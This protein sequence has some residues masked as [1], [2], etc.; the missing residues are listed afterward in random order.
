M[1]PTP[2]SQ[3]N[4]RIPHS[5]RNQ[6]DPKRDCDGADEDPVT[7]EVIGDNNGRCYP[8]SR[9]GQNCAR[10]VAAAALVASATTNQT[11]LIGIG[12]VLMVVVIVIRIGPRYRL[13]A[14]MTPAIVLFSS[15]S[16]A[17]V[18]ETGAQRFADTLIGAALVLPASAITI[19]WSPH[20]AIQADD[21]SA[22]GGHHRGPAT[23]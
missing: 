14:F 17:G 19:L 23:A 7:T 13:I 8:G 18:D 4:Q 10:H 1:L 15:T 5:H 3:Q 21:P 9:S 6:A 22:A 16:G 20:Q 11:V 12:P 2:T